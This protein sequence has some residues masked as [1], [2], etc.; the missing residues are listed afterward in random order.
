MVYLDPDLLR[1]GRSVLD[2]ANILADYYENKPVP[3]STPLILYVDDEVV[4]RSNGVDCAS[5]TEKIDVGCTREELNLVA[6]LLFGSEEPRVAARQGTTVSDE[7]ITRHIF[8]PQGW[9]CQK[10]A[11]G[12]YRMH[13]SDGNGSIREFDS[14]DAMRIVAA[15]KEAVDLIDSKD[16]FVT[17][18]RRTQEAKL[19]SNNI[20]GSKSTPLKAK[21]GEVMSQYEL[22]WTH[23]DLRAL[24]QIWAKD[25]E[26]CKH[27]YIERNAWRRKE[28]LLM[29]EIQRLGKKLEMKLG[30][31]R[32][33]D[34]IE[35]VHKELNAKYRLLLGRSRSEMSHM[36]KL[37]MEIDEDRRNL[38]RDNAG[39]QHRMTVLETTTRRERVRFLERM[40]R[41]ED[42]MRR[43]LERQRKEENDSTL[44][45]KQRL[46]VAQQKIVNLESHL[47]RLRG[48]LSQKEETSLECIP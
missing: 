30:G 31:H 27:L 41:M 18:R 4:C 16:P 15:S 8:L 6:A 33:G 1:P 36:T 10:T 14:A 20:E 29:N 19:R 28:E 44:A 13:W 24:R 3:E 39:M 32:R 45:W 9:F 43:T 25:H 40:E 21:G 17:V 2:P 26:A 5:Q 46:Q 11:P 7:A 38:A 22:P 35:S 37:L 12:R 23:E 47:Q 42:I 34:C 48:Y